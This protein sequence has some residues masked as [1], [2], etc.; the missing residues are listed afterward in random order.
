MKKGEG[1]ELKTT[2][3]TETVEFR[4]TSVG[5]KGEIKKIIEFTY[6]GENLW[7]LAFGDVKGDDWV[8]NVISDNNDFRL[9]LQTI[10]NAVHNFFEIYS[11]H[12]VQIVPL[13]YQRKLLYNRVFQQRWHEIQV[14]FEV[15]AILVKDEIIEVENYTPI[16]IFDAFVISQR[17]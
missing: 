14:L 4:F 9:V 11:D 5:E 6:L 8:D 7:N 15:K 10:T 3:Y 12:N 17:K 1:Y 13:D 16:K 2:N